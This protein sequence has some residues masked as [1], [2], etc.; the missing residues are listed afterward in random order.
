MTACHCD[1]CKKMSGG[2]NLSGHH[3]RRARPFIIYMA[4]WRASG[5]RLPIA[6]AR[7]MWCAVRSAARGCGMNPAFPVLTLAAGTLDDPYWVVPAT[8]IWIDKALAWHA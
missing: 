7:A 6:G 2:S 1:D 3:R 4:R 5:A 8:H